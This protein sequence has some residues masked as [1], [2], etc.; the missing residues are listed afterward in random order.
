VRAEI[1]NFF[2][3]LTLTPFIAEVSRIVVLGLVRICV[4]HALSFGHEMA[5]SL[6]RVGNAVTFA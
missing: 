5:R 4:V 2:E 3:E 6:L 1:S